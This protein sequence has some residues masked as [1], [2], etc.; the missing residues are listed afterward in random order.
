VLT[1]PAAL[2]EESRASLTQTL[3][4]YDQ[5]YDALKTMMD[6][7]PFGGERIRY[8]PDFEVRQVAWMLAG[9][10]ILY[11][12][13]NLNAAPPSESR[14]LDPVGLADSKPFELIRAMAVSFSR[15]KSRAY[16]G[17]DKAPQAWGG[18]LAQYALEQL[19]PTV[20]QVDPCAA[21]NLYFKS[22]N[23]ATFLADPWLQLCFLG[24]FQKKYGWDFYKDFF[25][26]LP[27][28]DDATE[29]VFFPTG[30]APKEVW[31]SLRT[32]FDLAAGESTEAIFKQYFLLP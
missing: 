29:T 6:A 2:A 22:G 20:M 23:A 28:A 7:E 8:F 26:N 17:G 18:L 10:P 27:E 25:S 11:D 13:K 16:Q 4:A 3:A 31:A 1:V 5:L 21:R 30:Q 14:I 24:E 32:L 19:G 9:N 15:A 12:P